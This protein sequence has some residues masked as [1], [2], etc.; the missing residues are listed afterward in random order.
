VRSALERAEPGSATQAVLTVIERCFGTLDGTLFGWFEF[1]E[2]ARRLPWWQYPL[3]VVVVWEHERWANL[4]YHRGLLEHVLH[5]SLASLAP[6]WFMA[7]LIGFSSMIKASRRLL[8]CHVHEVTT[9]GARPV[10]GVQ[11]A[12]DDF[13]HSVLAH[14]PITERDVLTTVTWST[15]FQVAWDQR[16]TGPF[17][18][19]LDLIKRRLTTETIPDVSLALFHHANRPDAFLS[20]RGVLRCGSLTD[21]ISHIG[22]DRTKASRTPKAYL[23]VLAAQCAARE[24]LPLSVRQHFQSGY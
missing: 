20:G 21:T 19:P 4:P 9:S 6:A 10:E 16:L 14:T 18:R 12:D 17:Q 8:Y 23:L 3:R 13:R 11:F 1:V 22:Y 7:P 15:S 24:G 2:Y 5:N